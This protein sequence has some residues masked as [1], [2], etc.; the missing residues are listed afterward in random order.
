M[1]RARFLSDLLFRILHL[2]KHASW[3]R[4]ICFIMRKRLWTREKPTNKFI[5][6]LLPDSNLLEDFHLGEILASWHEMEWRQ[7]KTLFRFIKRNKI[8]LACILHFYLSVFYSLMI[9]FRSSQ[10]CKRKWNEHWKSVLDLKSMRS[11]QR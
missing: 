5:S 2:F 3:S 1:F 11:K 8:F 7:K 6:T 10:C 4:A 9:F